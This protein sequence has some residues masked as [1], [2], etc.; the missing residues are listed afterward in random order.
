[1]VSLH[2][3]FFWSW[4]QSESQ[5][6]L[7]NTIGSGLLP[8]LSFGSIM[9]MSQVPK[10][11]CYKCL[12]HTLWLPQRDTLLTC[13]VQWDLIIPVTLRENRSAVIMQDL[14]NMYTSSS[15]RA[16][17]SLYSLE[18]VAGSWNFSLHQHFLSICKKYGSEEVQD[19]WHCSWLS[20]SVRI[21]TLSGMLLIPGEPNDMVLLSEPGTYSLQ[22]HSCWKYN[23]IPPSL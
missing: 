4:I 15:L 21:S 10:Y 2:F 8:V 12:P 16:G 17:G 19:A 9:S 11:F 13:S 14:L 22:L 7:H 20:S 3:V 1:M 5:A 23:L 18:T 6:S